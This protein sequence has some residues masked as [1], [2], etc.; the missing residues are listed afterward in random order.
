M[1]TLEVEGPDVVRLI[2]QF[3]REQGL[4][5]SFNALSTECQVSLNTIDSIETFVGDIHAGRWDVVLSQ[6]SRLK[7]PL[8]KL[9]DLHEQIL[10]EMMDL[11]EVE[12]CRAM[13]RQSQI[14]LA[15]RQDDPQRVSR[16]EGLLQRVPVDPY[17]L[18]GPP[19]SSKEKRR[20]AVAHA[21]TQEVSVVPPSRMMTLIGQALKWQQAQGLLPAGMAYD[22]FTGQLQS[23]RDLVDALP[24]ARFSPNGQLLV[25][26][27][28]DGFI[29]VWDSTTG[30]LKKDLSYQAEETFMIHDQARILNETRR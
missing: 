13:L 19:P 12:T 30:K 1:S 23:Q 22:I 17:E 8:A 28:V 5:E 27:S 18:Y 16:L 11:K 7:L 26:G 10:L 20:A 25:T 21:L 14:F 3:L 6:V 24:S 15:M 29:E 9:E 4:T 2:L